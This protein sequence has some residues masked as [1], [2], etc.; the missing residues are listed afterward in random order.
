ITVD[1]SAVEKG[2]S[3]RQV[4][5]PTYPWQKKRYWVDKNAY[6]EK[7]KS[8]SL[9][10]KNNFTSIVDFINQGDT[11]QLTEQLEKVGELSKNEI[12]LLPK[13]VDL[14]V[15]QHQKQLAVG[16]FED[17]FYKIEWQLKPRQLKTVSKANNNL[18]TAI[19]LI[20]ADFGGVAQAVA[21]YLQRKGQNCIL[22]YDRSTYH[23]E[24][25]GIFGLNASSSEDFERFF[26]EVLL[27]NRLS[28]KGVIHLW[29]LDAAQ[30]DDLTVSDLEQAQKKGCGSVL[31]LVQ[32]LVRH[33]NKP[34]LP[35]LWLVTRG[36]QQVN[37]NDGS[38]AVAQAPLWGLGKVIALEHSQLWG[39]MVDL[40]SEVMEDEVSMLM[41]EIEDSNGED[42]LAFRNGSRYVARL[43]REDLAPSQKVAF[44]AD[45]TYLI[46]GGLGAI[47]LEVAAWMVKQGVKHLVLTGRR[48][49]VSS[50]TEA[51]IFSMEELGARILVAK[52]DVSSLQ[53]MT[54]VLKEVSSSMPPLGGIIHAAGVSQYQT[55]EN[56]DLDT[57]ES[58]LRPKTIGTWVLHQL[59]QTLDIDF[60]IN[61]SSIASVWGSKGQAHYSA[62]NKFLDVFANHRQR[63]KMKTLSVNWGLW[64]SDGMATA[65]A[66]GILTRMGLKALQAKQAVII[67]EYLIG[68]DVSQITVANVDWTLFK[69]FYEARGQR[70]LLEKIKLQLREAEKQQSIQQSEILKQIEAAPERERKS[71]L[72]AHVQSEVS[73]A[74][75]L[76]PSQLPDLQQG[77]FDMGMDSLIA[78]EFLKRLETSLSC[79]LSSTLVFEFPTITKLSNYL[80]EEVLGWKSSK[81]TDAKSPH[82]EDKQLEALSEIETLEDDEVEVSIAQR[83]AKLQTLLKEG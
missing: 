37:A 70:L 23:Q 47:G 26:Q 80:S 72:I 18:E 38:L 71:I 36:V 79:S 64:A 28:V 20:F 51:A 45:R 68:L 15:E 12:K 29:S 33:H 54:R 8:I 21:E 77:F 31:Y 2:F 10:Q 9:L 69:E 39:G 34:V 3:Y 58:V 25:E 52:A 43:V 30:S 75:E 6:N 35:K 73:Q 62:A 42:H 17:W 27:K 61:F 50:E 11:Q 81:T 56:M 65:E 60:F 74:L 66:Q 4:I 63:L 7:Q 24:E 78:H 40:A 41:A 44:R 1:W 5:L 48:G 82:S 14:L 67:L 55:I 13:F 49:I 22:I 19:W 59:T 76:E 83:L 46:T 53:D 32:G 16:T 57:F